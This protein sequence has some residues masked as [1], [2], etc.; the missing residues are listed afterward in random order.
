MV[1]TAAAA[2]IL[3]GSSLLGAGISAGANALS[4]YK[5]FK[6][7]SQLQEQSARLGYKYDK[8]KA[9]NQYGWMRQGLEDANFNPYLAVQGASGASNASFAPSG[10]VDAPNYGQA[11]TN[12]IDIARLRNETMTAQSQQ[13][14]NEANASLS[15]AQTVAQ[16]LENDYIPE[17]NKATIANLWSQKELNEAT[18]NNFE[19]QLE[20]GYYTVNSNN[21][22]SVANNMRDN[23]MAK[24]GIDKGT[25]PKWVTSVG[26]A[27]G[28]GVG[29]YTAIRG[30]KPSLR[31]YR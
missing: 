25:P 1:V 6:Y 18:I 26:A 16:L 23:A 14:V 5:Q 31:K 20:L 24:Y 7:A 2:G 30:A 10:S 17:K 29:T 22:T 8:K 12:A 21:A 28:A 19:K 13:S 27:L 4:N 11:V 3:A 9:L 15:N